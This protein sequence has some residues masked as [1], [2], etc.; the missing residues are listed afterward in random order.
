MGRGFYSPCF[1]IP[2]QKDTGWRPIWDLH[3]CNIFIQKLKFRMVT[4]ISV[5]LQEG[6]WFVALN[7]KDTCFHV[8]SHLSPRKFFWFMI[9][10]EHLQLKA[11]LFGLAKAPRVFTK[12]FSVVAAQIRCQSYSFL[13][14]GQ[15]D[16]SRLFRPWGQ[17]SDF[18]PTPSS[19]SHGCLC[20][21]VEVH[22]NLQSHAGFPFSKSFPS[23]R[24]I[25]VLMRNLIA[26]IICQRLWSVCLSPESHDLTYLRHHSPGFIYN[27]YRPGFYLSHQTRTTWAPE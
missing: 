22:F 15:L 26:R 9:G 12:V 6:I 17:I 2:P 25:S 5:F 10:Q 11:L 7:M 13:L 14:I 21:Q 1:L 18:V 20:E 8:D 19:S 24:K 4:L 27:A 23:H 3:K 16:P